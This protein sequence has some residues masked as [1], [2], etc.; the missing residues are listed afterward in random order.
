MQTDAVEAGG[1]MPAMA[2]R[3]AIWGPTIV[4]ILG[5]VLALN[6]AL[7]DEYTGA[8]ACLVASALAF[9]VLAYLSL[10]RSP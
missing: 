10:R 2:F 1:F 5:V 8:G 3:M 9:G 4:G 7:S 6:A